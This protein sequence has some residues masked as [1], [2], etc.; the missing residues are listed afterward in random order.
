MYSGLTPTAAG[1][2]EKTPFVHLLV[3][4]ADHMLSGSMV[5]AEPNR[6][7]GQEHTIYFFQGSAS[8]VRTGEPIA[9]LG[10]VLF[11]LGFI[12]ESELN[13]SLMALGDGGELHGEALVRQGIIDRSKL[14]RALA[15]Q[16]NRKMA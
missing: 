11:E 7:Q 15:A 1:S 6:A 14:M 13:T 5:L 3:Y 4:V 12:N 8:K 16:L 10:R 2:L 9:H